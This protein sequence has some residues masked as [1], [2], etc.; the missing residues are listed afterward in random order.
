MACLEAVADE[1]GIPFK[2]IHLQSK[3]ETQNAPTPI[4]TYAVFHD[5]KHLTNEQ[6][7]D[8]RFLKTVYLHND[9]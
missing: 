7:N 1:N 9:K 8:K 4:T 2:A 3:E 6:M 5:G